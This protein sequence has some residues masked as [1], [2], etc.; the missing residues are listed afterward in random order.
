M[1]NVVKIIYKKYQE[2]LGKDP[3]NLASSDPGVWPIVDD[4]NVTYDYGMKVGETCK[5][6]YDH[7]QGIQYGR[8]EDVH[9]WN[10]IVE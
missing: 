3:D 9:N 10:V 8:V 7:L 1:T 4:N 5:K 6:M 2:N